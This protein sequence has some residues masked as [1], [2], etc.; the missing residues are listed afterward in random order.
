MK[1]HLTISYLIFF[2]I[3][4]LLFS[5]SLPHSSCGNT[6]GAKVHG[7]VVDAETGE[8]LSDVN[9]FLAN[10]TIGT[11]SGRSGDFVINN[12]PQG[13]YS[14]IVS[15]IGYDVFIKNIEIIGTRSL[16]INVRLQSKAIPGDEVVVEAE[17]PKNWE[18]NYKKFLKLFMGSSKNAKRTEI[19]NPY[20][21]S[22][23]TD[24]SRGKFYAFSD[25]AL[26]VK[27]RA[28]GYEVRIIFNRFELDK[29]RLIYAIYPH[30]REMKPI[31]PLQKIRWERQR[32]KTFLGSFKHFLISLVRNRVSEEG[33]ELYEIMALDRVGASRK[34]DLKKES[35]I[36]P[37]VC[38]GIFLLHF[39]LYLGVRYK[40]KWGSQETESVLSLNSPYAKIDSLGNVLN[41][42]A[43][44]IRGDW[45][46]QRIPDMLP[47]DYNFKK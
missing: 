25:S 45:T 8:P 7:K 40:A 9:I 33:F 37:D 21:L 38:D 24:N 16:T 19:V 47:L 15:R 28:L 12:V 39:D 10:T 41:A 1:T 30:Y 14:L 5:D 44:T 3:T 43:F 42:Y 46:R 20:I 4:F 22:F 2:F 17:K 6:R 34:I 35:L 27:N 11:A 18:K 32:K 29:D 23:S 13:S 31:N 36:Q 26:I